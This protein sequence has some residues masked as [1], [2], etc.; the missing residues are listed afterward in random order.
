M[1]F[2]LSSHPEA[3][4]PVAVRML[5]RLREDLKNHEA[6]VNSTRKSNLAVDILDRRVSLGEKK[7]FLDLLQKR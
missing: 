3:S 4:A 2:D 5:Q 6:Q 7:T 1:P